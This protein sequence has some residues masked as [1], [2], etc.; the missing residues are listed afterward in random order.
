MLDH[1][2]QSF[3]IKQTR[4]GE[5]GIEE[6]HYMRDWRKVHSGMMEKIPLPWQCGDYPAKGIPRL[7]DHAPLSIVRR[8][9]S[10]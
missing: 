1:D 5:N 4:Q 7:R 9:S 6:Y 3:A 10:D 2:L 8:G